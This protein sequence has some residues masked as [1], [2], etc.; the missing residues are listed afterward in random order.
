M[1]HLVASLSEV[2]KLSEFWQPLQF[3]LCASK[4]SEIFVRFG[5]GVKISEAAMNDHEH[6]M[7]KLNSFHLHNTEYTKYMTYELRN[8]RY[9]LDNVIIISDSSMNFRKMYG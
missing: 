5:M 4:I 2:P 3:Q 9:K 6:R 8:I 7:H 1:H